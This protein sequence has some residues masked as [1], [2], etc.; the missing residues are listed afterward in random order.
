MNCAITAPCACA[1]TD[2]AATAPLAIYWQ[3]K[4]GYFATS[5]SAVASYRWSF[6]SQYSFAS[7]VASLTAHYA[8]LPM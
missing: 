2:A 5:L 1:D 8:V 6:F 3:W 7:V 4:S